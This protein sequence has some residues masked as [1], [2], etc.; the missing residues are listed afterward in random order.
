MSRIF[1]FA[2]A[3]S[4]ILVASPVLAQQ[5]GGGAAPP[6]PAVTV[7]TVKAENVPVTFEYP[8]RVSSSREVEVRAQVG[9]I[10]LHRT[11][12]EGSRVNEGDL[13]FEIDRRPFEA[14]VALAEA[15][16]QQ[17]QATQANAR[18]T[19][20]R[21]Q[22][23]V[24]SGA[25]ST[26][27]LDDATS[28]RLL[29]DA[30]VAAAEAQLQT[31]TLSLDYASVEAPAGG[32]TSLEQVPEGSLLSTGDLLTRITQLDPA[33]VNFSAADSEAFSIRNMIEEGR[34]EGSLDQ[35]TV[36]VRFG[37]G[38]NYAQKGKIDFTSSSID[39]STGTI[40]SRAVLPNPDSQLLPGQFVRVEIEGIVVPDAV[41]IPTEALMQ[42]PQG[43][44]VYVL[45]DK[46]VAAVRPVTVGRELEGRLLI[47]EGLKPDDRV[48]TVGV[49]K[50]RPGSP[51]TPTDGQPAADGQP[52][53]G[54]A[55]EGEAAPQQAAAGAQP[56]AARS[57]ASQ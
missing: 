27:T 29:A 33:Y 4:A 32:I 42:G 41:T 2:S 16:L 57:E 52:Q 26:A 31:A 21:T 36:T 14:Q 25:T 44:F 7:M 5:P 12:N 18:R 8:A 35:L 22:S 51:V 9:G 54:G 13:L 47:A 46:N 3:L 34:A 43:T 1:P 40:L 55:Q 20:E 17:A 6:P 45:D 15:Q 37:N 10:L 56:G 53:A 28:Q 38:T 50:V 49:I 19:Q 39:Q 24:R 30:A 11:F 48:V 23:L